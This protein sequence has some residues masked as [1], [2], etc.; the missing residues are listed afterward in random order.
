[1]NTGRPATDARSANRGLGTQA[2][3]RTSG[4]IARFGPL[5]IA[6]LGLCLYLPGVGWGLPANSS[7]SQDTIAAFRTLGAVEGWPQLWQGRYPPLHYL[8]LAGAYQPLLHHW[9]RTGQRIHNP[10]TGETTLVPP[11]APKLATLILIARL[12]SVS[13]AIAAALGLLAATR[14]LTGDALAA[15]L[16]AI[17]FM[18]GAAFTYFAHLGNVDIPSACWFTWSV[19]FYVR[20]V[21]SSAWYDG[22]LLAL[23]GSLAI[24]T[25]DATAGMYPGMALVLIVLE[26][27]RHRER[28]GPLRRFVVALCQWKWLLGLAVFVLPYLFING[29]FANPDAYATRMKYWL[30]ITGDTLHTKQPR[31]PDQIRLFLATVYYAAGAVGWPMLLAMSASIVYALRRHRRW[32]LVVLVP[33]VGYYLLVIAQIDFVYSRFLLAP[34]AMV[35]MLLGVGAAALFRRSDQAV[36][37]RFG[38]PCAVL[39]LSVGYAGAVDAEMLTDTRYDVEAWFLANVEPPSAV[40]AFSK[41]QYLPRLTERGYATYAMTMTR[42]SFDRPQPDFL[43][44]TSYNYEDFDEEQKSCMADL[45]AGRLGYTL[46]KTVEHRWLGT[47]GLL[48]ASWLSLAG[49]AAPVPT[50]TC[51][52][53]HILRRESGPDG[54]GEN[55]A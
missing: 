33:A 30:G 51:P 15:L 2:V 38:V 43:I 48:P 42:A 37:V 22:A 28:F 50:K 9:D 27:A 21:R 11:H 54:R 13:M 25:K 41:P 34:I 44:L 10:Q 45:L 23:F 52:T 49:W 4:T 7:W 39:A 55:D 6:L 12:I 1:M 24:S 3:E 32:A 17:S 46:V 36:L 5:W 18:I 26:A 20:A 19:F 35:C 31:Y 40:G 8:I 47:A 16:A 53:I 29:V 14:S